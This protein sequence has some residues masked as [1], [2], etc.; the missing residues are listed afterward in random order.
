MLA[1]AL[2]RLGA[3]LPDLLGERAPS[4]LGGG[5]AGRRP[6]E[7]A[8]LLGKRHRSL[9]AVA[10]ADRRQRG[11]RRGQPPVLAE[12]PVEAGEVAGLAGLGQPQQVTERGRVHGRP[13]ARAATRIRSEKRIAAATAR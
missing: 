4:R 8:S 7:A 6:G 13:R 10:P 2:H 9:G 3:R 1:E 5:D 12:Q 11:D